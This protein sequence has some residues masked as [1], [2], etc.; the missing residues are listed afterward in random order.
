LPDDFVVMGREWLLGSRPT[1]LRALCAALRPLEIIWSAAVTIDVTDDP[2][3]VRDMALAGCTGVFVGFESLNGGHLT[4]SRK[5]T[6]FRKTMHAASPYST[7]TGS[8]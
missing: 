7:A 2:S 8:R 4:D 3:L 1:Y 5:R 6:P